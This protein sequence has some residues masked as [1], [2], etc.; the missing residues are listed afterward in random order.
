[1]TW[2]TMCS[3]YDPYFGKNDSTYCSGWDEK[4]GSG[5]DPNFSYYQKLGREAT[6]QCPKSSVAR[7]YR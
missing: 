3:K 7:D 6:E 2:C 1:M 5:R 4:L